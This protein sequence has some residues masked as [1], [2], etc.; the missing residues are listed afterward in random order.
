MKAAVSWMSSTVPVLSLSGVSLFHTGELY[1]DQTLLMFQSSLFGSYLSKRLS[2]SVAFIL[3]CLGRQS[4]HIEYK[5]FYVWN[6]FWVLTYQAHSF[7]KSCLKLFHEITINSCSLH[8]SL[9]SISVPGRLLG[10]CM[11]WEIILLALQGSGNVYKLLDIK[12]SRQRVSL[13]Q[14]R[15]TAVA[16]MCLQLQR[17][18]VSSGHST[19]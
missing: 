1:A 18:P 16:G 2:I 14:Q 5:G 4:V 6:S 19:M 15:W 10:V 8:S 17:D 3:G 7:F 9:S 13:N 11:S 12:P